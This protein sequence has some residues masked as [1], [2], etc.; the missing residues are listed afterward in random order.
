MNSRTLIL[1]L[2]LLAGLGLLSAQGS[3]QGP[4]DRSGNHV[5]NEIL[6]Q[7]R[8]GVT[9]EGRAA[10]RA[11]VGGLRHQLLMA[12]TGRLDGKGDLELMRLPLGLAVAAAAR[13][14]AEA[15]AV[16]FAEPNWIYQH[17]QGSND[18]FYN[19]G[20]LWGMYG[21]AT[22]P[23]NQYGSQAG[24]AWAI[25]IG[26]A[27]LHVAVIDEGVM[28]SHK[29]LQANMW[30]NPGDSTFNGVDE[31]GNGRVDD[32]TGWDFD[33]NNNS[34]YDGL[35]D[36]HGTHVAGTIGAVGNNNLG[37]V[38]V[39]WDVTLIPVKFLGVQGGTTANAIL[40][41]NYVTDLKVNRGI[42]IVATNNSWGGGGF[43]TALR[44][45]IQAGCNADILFIAAAGNS[46]INTD[47]APFYPASYDVS[48]VIAVAS[49]ASSGA[50][51]SFSNYGSASVDLGAPGQ[52]IISTMVSRK[53]NKP[54]YDS[55]S[56]T[57]M[58]TP[59]VTGAAAL[60]KSLNTGA[61]AAQI[62]AAI[63]GSVTPTASL[64]GKTVTGGRLNV[65]RLVGGEP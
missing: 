14:L 4:P 2:L 39:N 55:Y 5:P 12:A 3:A 41:V 60:Y 56:G 31:D 36:D 58:A 44:D 30:T 18:P 11:R 42:N 57:S 50:L 59:H 27:S 40:A 28:G 6:V 53:A 43:S 33:G 21:D 20:V 64:A 38:G 22:T 34:T 7:F 52:G 29:D 1:W 63:L 47:P 61:A 37:V 13:G 49:I 65:N 45:A 9:P 51:S 24:E 32:V 25:G 23:S 10:A 8:A 62:R 15:S 48:C 46:G 35:Q 19:S 17:Q 26:S 16:E 54:L